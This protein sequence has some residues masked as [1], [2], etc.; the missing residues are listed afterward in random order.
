MSITYC[1]AVGV[2]ILFKKMRS[3]KRE[4][5]SESMKDGAAF[6]C[7]VATRKTWVSTQKKRHES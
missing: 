6:R 3:S 1:F 4:K 2:E 5:S 7:M